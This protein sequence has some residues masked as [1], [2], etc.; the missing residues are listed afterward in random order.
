MKT[1]LISLSLT[2]IAL[3]AGCAAPESVIDATPKRS[4]GMV[5]TA[6]PHA[7]EAGL[8]ILR[9]GGS[10]VDAAVAIEAVLSLVEPQSSG[11]AGGAYMVHYDAESKALSVYDGRE[12][13]PAS[14]S[15][16]MFVGGDG[17]RLGFLDAKNS[18]LATGV[19]G[20][21][22][23]LA[24]A[25]G[26]HGALA[27]QD[28]F[29]PAGRLARDGFK[30][31]PR[32]HGMLTRFGRYIPATLAEGPLDAHNYFFDEAGEPLPLGHVLKN[33]EYAAALEIIAADPAAF[34][35]G[36]IARGI[37]DTVRQSPR[38]GGMTLEDIA[39]YAASKRDAI[40]QAYRD[41]QVCGP[42][43]ASSWIAVGMIMGL[44]DAS[45]GFSDKGAEDAQNWA[46]F[47]DAQRLAYAD[48]DQYIA[49]P[50]FVSVPAEGLLNDDYIKQ[51]A[52]LLSPGKAIAGVVPG[53]PWA[54]ETAAPQ[55]AVGVDATSDT[56][57]TTHFVVIDRNGNVV[58]MTASVESIFGSTRMV[59]GMFLNNQLTDFSF[60][61]VDAKGLPIANAPAPGK[62]PRS[63]M[64][65]TIVL[66]ENGEFLMATGSPGGNNIIAYA[67]K[68]LVGVLDWGLSAQEAVSLPNVVARGDVVR[69][70]TGTD[71]E[72][73]A[74]ELQDFGYAVDATGGENSG[75]SVVVRR[76]GGIL[77]GGVDP[78]RE[79]VVGVE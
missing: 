15:P 71:S 51:R 75:L 3:V 43:P 74:S 1:R 33:P 60:A 19:P 2:I 52:A 4:P 67:A 59:G 25:H 28:L 12:T 41:M 79:G 70:E 66:D 36:K 58:S 27:W 46:L 37:V 40:C 49:D 65:P 69:V 16:D 54:F 55:A 6:N 13:A 26:D 29:E 42:P 23:M 64:A 24:M 72:T 10:A 38:G 9:S 77:E 53:D 63:S 31:S 35:R 32:L 20:A 5:V 56:P 14:A 22:A 45:A 61:A 17:E 47:A 11:L 44:L 73:L 78:R 48:R 50:E 30:I 62:R 7:S 68:T 21:V 8:A 39:A 34:Y 76:S 18:G 57:G